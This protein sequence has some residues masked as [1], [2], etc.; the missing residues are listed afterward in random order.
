MTRP[1]VR[2]GCRGLVS[3]GAACALALPLAAC[4]GGSHHDSALPARTPAAALSS[5][6]ATPTV[7]AAEYDTSLAAAL[8]PLDRSLRAVDRAKTD[9]ALTHA[10][11]DAA[12]ASTTAAESVGSADTP[13]A[14]VAGNT[15]LA[16]AL[17]DLGD[18]LRSARGTG[19]RCATS[20]RVEMGTG[21]YL[22]SVRDAQKALSTL[23]YTAPLTLPRTARAQHRRLSNGHFIKD[24]RRSGLGRLTIDNDSD[25]D[26]VISVGKGRSVSFMV[27]VREN[28]KV[29]VRGVRNGSYTVYFTTDSDWSAGKESFTR[30][31]R[32]Q[33]FDD[34][35]KFSTRS[36]TGG[37]QYDVLT[38]SL[39]LTP[40]GNATTSE[41]PAGDFPS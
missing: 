40:L 8:G 17:R 14:A 28:H 18:G 11:G 26:A 9:S 33:K 12:A 37:T 3:A 34:R 31:C 38:F 29:T 16:Q 5:A 21:T 4:G 36:V 20:P 25:S 35:A 41:V 23:G 32:F 2:S 39:G 10:L 30:D 6:S 22:Q 19:D 27:Y 15:R 13:D 1:H 24:S 7:S